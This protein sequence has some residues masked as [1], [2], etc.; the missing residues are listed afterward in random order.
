MPKSSTAKVLSTMQLSTGLLQT[1]DVLLSEMRSSARLG[2]LERLLERLLVTSCLAAISH[3]CGLISTHCEEQ[4][5]LE[6]QQTTAAALLDLSNATAVMIAA[7]K[8][9]E[10]TRWQLVRECACA[11]GG[12]GM[13]C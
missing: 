11:T 12:G 13:S 8:M 6:V 3:A 1:L 4:G 10:P 2:D 5:K 9:E 7:P